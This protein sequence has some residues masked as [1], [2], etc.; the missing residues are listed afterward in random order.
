VKDEAGAVLG[1]VEG[2]FDTGDTGVMVVQGEARAHD[3]V[4]AGIREVGGPRG[5][6]HHGGLEGG[7][8]RVKR[9][10]VVTIFPEMFDALVDHGIT[11]ARAGREAVRS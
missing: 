4:R 9:F 2:F 10:D 11:R 6:Q 7:L 8:R 3:P 5:A 1:R